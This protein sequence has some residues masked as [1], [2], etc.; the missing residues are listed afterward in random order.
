LSVIQQQILPILLPAAFDSKVDF[1]QWM[2]AMEVS[3]AKLEG[4][5]QDEPTEINSN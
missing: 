1:Q 5:V 2:S 3:L 4:E